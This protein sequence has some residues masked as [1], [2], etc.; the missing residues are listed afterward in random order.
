MD[1]AVETAN[2]AKKATTV[3]PKS[4][5]ARLV[6]VTR[7]ASM[8]HSPAMHGLVNASAN[9][10]LADSIVIDVNEATTELLLIVSPAESASTVGTE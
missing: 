4:E 6:T 10:A 2:L 8:I 7:A 1:S 3:I 9:P 5:N